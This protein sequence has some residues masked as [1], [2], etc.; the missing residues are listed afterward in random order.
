MMPET[1]TDQAPARKRSAASYILAAIIV[2]DL[3]LLSQDADAVHYSKSMS[4]IVK[5]KIHPDPADNCLCTVAG[6]VTNAL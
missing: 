1:S 5:S 3:Y 4:Y 6:N 2:V